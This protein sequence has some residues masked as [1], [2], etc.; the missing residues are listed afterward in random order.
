M[1]DMLEWMKREGYCAEVCPWAPY[2]CQ[3]DAGH[4]G[5][6]AWESTRPPEAEDTGPGHPCWC[7]TGLPCAKHPQP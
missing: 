3:L 1:T 5:E 6:H 2:A 4:E 7:G